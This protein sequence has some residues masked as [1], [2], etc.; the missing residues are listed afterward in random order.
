VADERSLQVEIVAPD[1]AVYA[2]TVA[3]VVAPG[4]EG[5]LGILPRHEPLVSLLAI[6]ETRVRRLD[7][8]WEHLPRNLNPSLAIRAT[9]QAHP[10][11]SPTSFTNTAPRSSMTA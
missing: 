1:G 8:D 9:A 5:Q 6:G 3:M 2:D 4:V 11:P 10:V 7:G